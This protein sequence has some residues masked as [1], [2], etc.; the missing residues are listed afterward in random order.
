MPAILTAMT[1]K[2]HGSALDVDVSPYLFTAAD[3]HVQETGLF[4]HS[5]SRNT[6]LSSNLVER[7]NP[8]LRDL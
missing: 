3:V 8:L 7:K 5:S 2:L 1:G 6:S 4:H